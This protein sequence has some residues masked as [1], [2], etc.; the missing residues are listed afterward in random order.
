M[1]FFFTHCPIRIRNALGSVLYGVGALDL[2]VFAIAIVSLVSVA[3]IACILPARRATQVD[4]IVAL[5]SEIVAVASAESFQSPIYFPIDNLQPRHAG[6]RSLVRSRNATR[7]QKQNTT[8][9]F[10]ARHMR[11]AV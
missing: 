11:M 3:L 6:G 2:P 1:R 9:L 4:P 10:L 5:R 7:I 8:S